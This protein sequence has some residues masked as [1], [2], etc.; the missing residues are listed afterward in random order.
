MTKMIEYNTIPEFDKDFKKLEKRFRTLAQDFET[1]K[2]AVIETHYL[3]NI[4][5]KAFV[6]I[7]SLCSKNYQSLKVRKFS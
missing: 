7:E 3:K 5:T 4:P 6:P 2:K 1:M